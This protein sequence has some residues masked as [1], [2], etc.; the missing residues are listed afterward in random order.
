MYYHAIIRFPSG[1]EFWTNQEYD[2]VVETLVIP[3]INKQINLVNRGYGNVV[4]NFGIGNFLSVF[5]T[6][7]K[8]PEGFEKVWREWSANAA[9][10]FT[11]NDYT[12]QIIEEALKLKWAARTKSSIEISLLTTKPQ[13]FIIMKFGDNVLESAYEC[14]IK[15]IIRRFKYH[16]LRIDEIQDAGRI[17]NQIIEEIARSEIVLA[18][19]T[20]ERPNCYYEA[21]FAHAHG[22]VMILTIK[23]GSTRHFD[24]DGYRFIEW[25]TEG[26][27]KKELGKRF[28]AIKQRA[29]QNMTW[30]SCV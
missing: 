29:T 12:Q 21:G 20:G 2:E 26:E 25:E 4:V 30:P 23:K 17:S 7:Y 5:R 9:N 8:L 22:K 18:D 14:V 6:N 11:K 15:P 16:P 3:Y 10:E 19:L 1:N 28:K 13:V 24:I 27:L